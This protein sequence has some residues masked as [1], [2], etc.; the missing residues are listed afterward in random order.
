MR[1]VFFGLYFMLL[2][3]ISGAQNS[4][5]VAETDRYIFYSNFWINQHHFLYNMA[6]E[7]KLKEWSAGFSPLVL[8]TMNMQEREILR[9]AIEYYKE[10]II[11]KDLLMDEQMYWTKRALIK[12]DVNE[13]LFHQA[14]D[15]VHQ[16]I[17]NS[18]KE[19]Y[20][21]YFWEAH[22]QQ[23]KKIVNE[24]LDLIKKIENQVFNRIAELAQKS[25]PEEKIRVDISF[26]SNWAG[27]YC[28]VNPI[29]VV[30]ISNPDGPDGNWPEYGWL[31]LL[32]HEPSHAVV[33]PGKYAVGTMIKEISAELKTEEPRGLW[34]AILFYFSGLA[35]QEQL[36]EEGID[37]EL[38][39]MT[40]D[41]FSFYHLAMRN[42]MSS[43]AKGEKSLQAVITE[44]IKGNNN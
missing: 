26:Y 27:A 31:E 5:V 44:I 42:E 17:L 4:N 30:L 22:D 37:H 40:N 8:K 21:K 25:W 28:T 1:I 7:A 23:N 13:K 10:D 41:I 20:R 6:E 33:F 18:T 15:Q 39:M 19:V 3:T 36:R 38:I 2:S 11:K 12:F 43:Y 35:V 32:F 9:K 16:D 14:I 34:H 29:H 24:H